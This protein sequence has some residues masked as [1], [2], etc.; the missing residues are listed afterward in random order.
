MQLFTEIFLP[1]TGAPLARII[2]L[3]TGFTAWY[4]LLFMRN[5]I[6][7]IPRDPGIDGLLFLLF[8]FSFFTP[9]IP[10][11]P[12]YTLTAT[13][14]FLYLYM[15]I[16]YRNDSFHTLAGIIAAMAS[17]FLFLY[18]GQLDSS[19]TERAGTILSGRELPMT[20]S[21]LWL[22]VVLL[23]FLFQWRIRWGVRAW[24]H[25]PLFWTEEKWVYHGIGFATILSET[26]AIL[27]LFHTMGFRA[28]LALYTI[29]HPV[30]FLSPF[31]FYGVSSLVIYLTD[32]PYSI[33]IL[34]GLG[35]MFYSLQSKGDSND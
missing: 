12:L 20:A 8:S 5:S 3:A 9:F 32:F 31:I 6:P 1:G 4:L 30:G 29:T 25:G 15:L 18:I 27:L 17:L 10:A 2:S 19:V 35:V 23:L 33:I 26:V 28:G 21:L 24:I 22:P 16:K 11:I 34:V 13:G 14:S 7:T